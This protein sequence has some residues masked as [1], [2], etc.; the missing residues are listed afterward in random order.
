MSRLIKI[1]IIVVLNGLL[2]GQIDRI[3]N[4]DLISAFIGLVEGIMLMVVLLGWV[5]RDDLY[6]NY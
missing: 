5:Y 2:L 6:K 1:I 4:W 3:Y